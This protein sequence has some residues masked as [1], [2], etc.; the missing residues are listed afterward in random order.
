MTSP[1]RAVVRFQNDFTEVFLLC[2]YQI[3]KMIPFGWTKWSSVLK[4]EKSLKDIS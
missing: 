4:I 1:S 3:V 2:L